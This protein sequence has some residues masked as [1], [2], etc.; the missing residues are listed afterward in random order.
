M[1]GAPDVLKLARFALPA[2]D[3][4]ID[5]ALAYAAAGMRV[6]PISANKKPLAK[7]GVKDASTGEAAI[8]AWWTRQPHAGVAWAV[9]AEIVVADLDCKRGDNGV[10][11]FTAHEGA[12][13]DDV[14]TPQ[15]LTP[16]GGRHVI[17]AANGAVYRNNVRLNGSAIDL[18]TAG[19]Y[20]ALPG[21]ANGRAW[22]KP[23]AT[24]LAPAPRWI[25]PTAKACGPAAARPFSGETPYARVALERACLAIEEAPNGAQ[26]ATLNKECFSIGGLIGAGELDVEA[27]ISALWTAADAMPHYAE[28]WRDLEAKVRRAVADGMGRPRSTAEPEPKTDGLIWYGDEPSDAA[29]LPRRRD[30]S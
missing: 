16:T 10:K 13:P 15:A 25:A 30:G 21:P 1:N 27:A 22:I 18:R 20:I 17:Y 6:F 23:L 4:P 14:M 19:G 29:K 2:S 12:H 5:W 24:P 7:H 11:D 28:P 26:E 8:R 9:P 3:A